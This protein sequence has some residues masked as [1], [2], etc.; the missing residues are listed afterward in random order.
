VELITPWSQEQ[1][2]G[3]C[4]CV[5]YRKRTRCSKTAS[6][7]FS[8]APVY[9]IKTIFCFERWWYIFCFETSKRFAR[10]CTQYRCAGVERGARGKGGSNWVH[11]RYGRAGTKQSCWLIL[12]A[13][14]SCVGAE[15][16]AKGQ[17]L[18]DSRK[19]WGSYIGEIRVPGHA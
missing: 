1:C 4:Y 5:L 13:W 11:Q 15:D 6:S 8:S 3:S 17:W 7:L 19:E 14:L 2:P 16:S 12:V 10:R 18:M 9:I